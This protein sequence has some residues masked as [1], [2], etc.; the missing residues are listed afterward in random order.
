LAATG[1][2]ALLSVL[3]RAIGR[4]AGVAQSEVAHDARARLAAL[5]KEG[6]SHGLLSESQ[7]TL[8]DRALIF[9]RATVAGD[10][11]PWSGAR[12]VRSA[13]RAPE[14][15]RHAAGEWA[16]V[17]TAA[18]A[19]VGVVRRLDLLLAPPDAEVGPLMRQLVALKPDTP[20]H[21]AAAELA[22]AR[23]G[24]GVVLRGGR[25][26]GVVTPEDLAEPLTGDLS[27]W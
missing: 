10:M 16:P 21:Q 13:A 22:R 24:M 11:T 23:V 12:P 5:L 17:I 6:A 18:G 8:L 4:V 3:A 7:T 1:L 14:A 19:P 9:S 25:P 27:S 26:A 15:A 20:L 2:P